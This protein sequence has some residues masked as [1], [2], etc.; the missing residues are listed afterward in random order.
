MIRRHVHWALAVAVV[1][2]GCSRE[3]NKTP[4]AKPPAPTPTMTDRAENPVLDEAAARKKRSMKKLAA[5]GVPY[6]EYLP[7]IETAA[8]AKLRTKKAVTE[9]AVALLVVALKGEGLPHLEVAAVAKTLGAA[10]SLS[11]DEKRFVSDPSPDGPHAGSV[12][13][14]LR[15]PRRDAVGP[16]FPP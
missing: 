9:R 6:T 14:A 12:R 1:I 10:P 4:P 16:W 2:A 7:V 13:L 8:E 11:P 15:V 3:D 5:E